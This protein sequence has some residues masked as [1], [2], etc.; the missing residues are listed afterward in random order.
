MQETVKCYPL[1]GLYIQYVL[2][3]LILAQRFSVISSLYP[4]LVSALS[5]TFGMLIRPQSDLEAK[6]RH[7]SDSLS[8]P[9]C[10]QIDF[11]FHSIRFKGQASSPVRFFV[12]SKSNSRLSLAL[13]LTPCFQFLLGDSM[14]RLPYPSLLS[15]TF[16][17]KYKSRSSMQSLD[18]ETH[19]FVLKITLKKQPKFIHCLTSIFNLGYIFL[20]LRP[21]PPFI[22]IYQLKSRIHPQSM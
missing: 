9:T 5:L 19:C 16:G 21:R 18:F 12:A 2:Y 14:R 13:F 10:C 22:N 3:F 6:P 20:C 15:V 4:S 7:L 17:I 8:F 11:H 1:P